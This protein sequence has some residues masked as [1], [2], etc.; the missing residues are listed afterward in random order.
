MEL[1]GSRER[2]REHFSGALQKKSKKLE[3]SADNT[4]KIFVM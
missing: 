1:E 3:K 4:K 2:I